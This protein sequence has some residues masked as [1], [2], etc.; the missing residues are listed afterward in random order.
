M[1]ARRAPAAPV[2]WLVRSRTRRLP[3]VGPVWLWPSGLMAAGGG[4][5][6]GGDVAELVEVEA[7]LRVGR[8]PH[9]EGFDEWVGGRVREGGVVDCRFLLGYVSA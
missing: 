3:S 9:D 7:V 5:V 2:G 1:T 8:E 4:A 6:R